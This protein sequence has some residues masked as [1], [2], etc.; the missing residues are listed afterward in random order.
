[1]VPLGSHHWQGWSNPDSDL[2]LSTFPTVKRLF[3]M[4]IIQLANIPVTNSILKGWKEK[5]TRHQWSP[6]SNHTIWPHTDNIIVTRKWHLRTTRNIHTIYI[7]LHNVAIAPY[8]LHT[9]SQCCY[10]PI[11]SSRGQEAH[12]K[13]FSGPQM[14]PK[15]LKMQITS[16][17]ELVV[18]FAERAEMPGQM[19]NSQRCPA[20]KVFFFCFLSAKPFGPLDSSAKPSDCSSAVQRFLRVIWLR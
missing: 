2:R 6:A 18:F 8:Q 13:I 7:L 9:S 15:M 14:S 11:P 3:S 12:V 4:A 10:S 17:C 20:V 1:M 5:N 19:W 16:R